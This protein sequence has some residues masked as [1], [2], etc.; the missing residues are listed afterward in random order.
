MYIQLKISYETV[1]SCV[2][3]LHSYVISLIFLSDSA[4]SF[5]FNLSSENRR[6]F[7]FVRSFV[8][9]FGV[10]VGTFSVVYDSFPL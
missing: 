5:L 4:A 10:E 2:K 3:L 8:R 9:P 7:S 6:R 1:V